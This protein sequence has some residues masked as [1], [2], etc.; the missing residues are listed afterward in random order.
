MKKLLI[1]SAV[2]I[3]LT[4]CGSGAGSDSS[5][6]SVQQQ[7]SL[8]DNGSISSPD[9]SNN[10]SGSGTT[11]TTDS[12]TTTDP[13]PG[14]DPVTNPDP[15]PTPEPGAEPVAMYSYTNDVS[16]AVPLAG[17]TLEQRTVY[18]FWQGV[19]ANSVT[20][21]CCKG[22]SGEALG[23]S[24][25]SPVTVNS[26]PYA[27]AIDLSNY[28]TSGSRELYVDYQ[29]STGTFYQDNFTQFAINV[30]SSSTT[31]DPDP[32]PTY[33][34]SAQFEWEAPTRREDGSDLTSSEIASYGIT[35]TDPTGNERTEVIS[36][37]TTTWSTTL[38]TGSYEFAIY[39]I[40]SSGLHSQLSDTISCN[41]SETESYCI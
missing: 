12:G 39:A 11:D 3:F 1:A 26:A 21:Y 28:T 41:I 19:E 35:Y 32:A 20:Y 37:S 27:M 6:S 33:S 34:L 2:S 29:D 15:S 22:L 7:D 23:E 18:I 8:I 13:A 36:S 10:N 24:H 40:D 38:M 31:P 25:T 5:S 16:T 17:A 4:A 9:S 30:N 14:T